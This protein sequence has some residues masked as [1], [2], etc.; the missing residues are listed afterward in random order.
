MRKL[1]LAAVVALVVLRGIKPAGAD[2]RH[3]SP[4]FDAVGL[5]LAAGLVGGYA[6]GTGYFIH[7]DVTA[8]RQTLEYGA[9]EATVNILLG[10]LFT[11]ATVDAV[12]HGHAVQAAVL[13]AFALTHGTLTGHGLWRVYQHRGELRPDRTTVE[14]AVA[15]AYASSTLMWG[16]QA[17]GDH[18]RAY[19]ITEAAV[20][21]PIAAALG[22]LAVDRARDGDTPA[23][24]LYG[25]LAT[26]SGVLA[27]HGVRTAM[28]QNQRRGEEPID[29][30]LDL[31]L[32]GDVEVAPTVVTDGKQLAPGVGASGAW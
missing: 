2:C 19:G 7:R 12:R 15:L 3:C 20:N 31:G 24:M 17:F 10:S 8:D 30:G 21:T 32:G 29:F 11:G 22:Y 9:T 28:V 18:G 25:G 14:R 5:T 23:A 13:G 4:L 6:Y 1:V 27:L 26:V 16:L